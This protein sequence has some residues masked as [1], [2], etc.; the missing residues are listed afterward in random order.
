MRAVV[1]PDV[2]LRLFKT[3]AAGFVGQMFVDGTEPG[4]RNWIVADMAAASPEVAISAMENMLADA[5]SGAVLDAFDG[6]EVPLMA[7]NA[8][9]WPT[10]VEANR[11]HLPRFEAA[12]VEGTDH[13]L[14]MAE[15]EAFNRALAEVIGA[16]TGSRGPE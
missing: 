5:V 2:S 10:E 3:R 14:H 13:F 12:I 9:L 4:L 7:I 8:D 1:L 15:P 11:S 16:L 6:L